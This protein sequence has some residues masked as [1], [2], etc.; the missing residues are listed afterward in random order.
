MC[1]QEEKVIFRPLGVCP[2]LTPRFSPDWSCLTGSECVCVFVLHLAHGSG[3]RAF[4]K[5]GKGRPCARP[6][7][8]CL[9]PQLRSHGE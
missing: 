3:G 2:P 1:V 9:L 7:P 8:A 4:G 5:G 6:S